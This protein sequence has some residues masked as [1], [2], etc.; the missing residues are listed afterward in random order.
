MSSRLEE[1]LRSVR[2]RLEARRSSVSEADLRARCQERS[3]ARDFAESLRRPSKGSA[4]APD[5]R[6]IGELKRRS[7][8]AGAI[9]EDLDPATAAREL[10]DAGCRAL[11]VLTEPD[12]FGGSL[13][14]LSVV[15]ERVEVPLLRK[16][17][18][19]DP[20]QV[21][22]ARAHGADAVLLLAAVLDDAQLESCWEAAQDLGLQ[23]LAEAH[24]LEELE[25]IVSM[26]FPVIG[27][28]ARDLVTFD[29]D[30]ERA[31][32]WM[33]SVPEDRIRVAESG[34][35]SRQDAVLVETAPVDAVLVGEGLMRGGRPAEN[36]ARL[37]RRTES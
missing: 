28:N 35:R 21:V 34:V 15:R 25:R 33:G 32:A 9:R 17:F 30:L 18:V 12:F 20:Y 10:A 3:P 26:G 2:A 29:V 19:V 27:V 36:F 23:V 24:G 7:P 22:E 14:T 13:E 8:S 37:F 6:V 4:D 5:L 1:I 31:L 11:S 16:D